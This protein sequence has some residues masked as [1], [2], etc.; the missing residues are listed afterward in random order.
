MAVT[1]PA[2]S[3]TNQPHTDSGGATS[4]SHPSH[5]DNT[6]RLEGDWCNLW[7]GAG[8]RR[9]TYGPTDYWGREIT[10]SFSLP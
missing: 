10:D 9:A 5:Q 6:K 1:G 7:G 3:V 2:R 4:W 8:G